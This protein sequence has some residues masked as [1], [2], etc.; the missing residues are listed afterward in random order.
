MEIFILVCLLAPVLAKYA[1]LME[2]AKRGFSLIAGAGALYLLAYSFGQTELVVE[3]AA[4]L[5]TW[6]SYLFGLI[7]WIFV[8][9][10]ALMVAYK[11]AMEE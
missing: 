1:G 4:Q 10:G 9:V 5:A 11:L 8:L 6:G 3:E 2:K 7:G